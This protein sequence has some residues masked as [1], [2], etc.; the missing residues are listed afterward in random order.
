LVVRRAKWTNNFLYV[1]SFD[2]WRT[3]GGEKID[4]KNFPHTAN[5]DVLSAPSTADWERKAADIRKAAAWALGDEPP[6][7][8]PAAA[9]GR[10]GLGG[11]GPGPRRTR[12]RSDHG[13]R[14]AVS[15]IPASLRPMCGV[16]DLAW[17][18]GIR[19][20]EPEKNS[21]ESRKLRFGSGVS[22]DLYFP[23][24]T[25]ENTKLPTVDLAARFSYPLGYMWF[26]GVICIRSSRS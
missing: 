17:W 21:V 1:W 23:A 26:I 7:M 10:G 3:R 2:D 5:G 6:Q 13:L 16:G 24:G 11:R 8:A 4:L 14:R 12:P 18:S 15:A 19:L 22:G 20:L 25:P 9:G